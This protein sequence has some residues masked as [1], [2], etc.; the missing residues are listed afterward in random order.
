MACTQQRH[1]LAAA[2]LIQHRSF[3]PY[4]FS[5]VANTL[6]ARGFLSIEALPWRFPVRDHALHERTFL[7][8]L[9]AIAAVIRAPDQNGRDYISGD[10]EVGL[11]AEVGMGAYAHAKEP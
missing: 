1:A 7:F 6:P 3:L 8:I 2:L 9:R 11:A 5:H 10:G 4:D